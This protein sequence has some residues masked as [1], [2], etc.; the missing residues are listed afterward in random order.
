MKFSEEQVKEIVALK[1][2]LIEQINKHQ[3]GIEMLEKRS[4]L[5][6]HET[7]LKEVVGPEVDDYVRKLDI[8]GETAVKGCNGF[9]TYLDELKKNTRKSYQNMIL[10]IEKEKKDLEKSS[11]R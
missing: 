9:L 7:Y 11:R 6:F 8:L 10:K 2:N 4:T 1:E 3:E 5:N